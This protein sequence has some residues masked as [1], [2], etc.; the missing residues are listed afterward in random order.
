MKWLFSGVLLSFLSGC[1]VTQ[2][3][4]VNYVDEPDQVVRVMLHE[5]M[6][7]R[8]KKK[9]TDAL[10][11]G[12][13]LSGENDW[14]QT[15]IVHEGS[16][17][18]AKVRL[19]GDLKEH[20][21]HEREWS[22]KVKLEGNKK[23]MGMNRFALQRAQTRG[24]LNEWYLHKLLSYSG[25]IALNYDFVSVAINDDL[26]PVYAVEENFHAGLLKRHNRPS[27][28]FFQFNGD[29][30]WRQKPGLASKFYGTEITAFEMS[31]VKKDP[32]LLKQLKHVRNQ[33]E[34][35]RNKAIPT[36]QIF[37]VDQMAKLFVAIDLMGHHHATML[38]NI[39]FYY[40]TN[41]ELIEPIGYDNEYISPLKEQGLLG[42]NKK[43]GGH[44][45]IDEWNFTNGYWYQYLFADSVFMDAYLKQAQIMSQKAYL[46]DFFNEIREEAE[47]KEVFIQK[48]YS[49]YSFNKADL[50]YENQEYIR[51]Q[52]E[53]VTVETA[54]EVLN[55]NEE[56]SVG[57]SQNSLT[58]ISASLR[59]EDALVSLALLDIMG[60]NEKEC[61]ISW[62]GGKGQVQELKYEAITNDIWGTRLKNSTSSNAGPLGNEKAFREYIA[63]LSQ[64]CNE[65]EFAKYGKKISWLSQSIDLSD[66]KINTII[67]NNQAYLRDFLTPYRAAYFNFVGTNSPAESIVLLAKNIHMLPLEIRSVS[68][69]DQN[70]VLEKPVIIPG[71]N[72][73]QNPPFIRFEVKVGPILLKEIVSMVNESEFDLAKF[74]LNYCLLGMDDHELSGKISR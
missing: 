9:R 5:S 11:A 52:I 31:R 15:V 28:V 1:G 71:Y 30:Y 46:D 6:L 25:L 48:S 18:R 38:D 51:S 73:G 23:I 66:A 43:Q 35:F 72:I 37:D 39:R 32:V 42:S 36:H 49:Q 17:K 40:N 54:Y 33:V 16:S 20:W 2:T 12:K 26:F 34:K 62:L 56:V 29:F 45:V 70:I 4:T 8:L 44:Y 67:Q 65:E 47:E 19:K 68:I 53:G 21:S 14:V 27:G 58:G 22:F 57:D 41:N 10:E 74:E 24:F 64:L 55:A 7:D 63:T 60:C 61:M 59:R 50:I 13:L 3:D 69:N